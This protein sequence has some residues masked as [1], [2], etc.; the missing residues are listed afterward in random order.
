MLKK[1]QTKGLSNELIIQHFILGLIIFL[2]AVIKSI[3]LILPAPRKAIKSVKL[4]SQQKTSLDS[5]DYKEYTSFISKKSNNELKEILGNL[6]IFST[7]SRKALAD[8]LISNKEALKLIK[9]QKK[10]ELLEKMTN[11]EIRELLKGFTRISR[12]KKSQL[13]EL[14]LKKD[15]Y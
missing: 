2:E 5:S 13:I 14:V 7:I 8:L 6:D 10:R 1:T 3:N 9:I 11:Q 12:L 15:K 4:L